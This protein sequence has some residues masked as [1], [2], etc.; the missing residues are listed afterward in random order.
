MNNRDSAPD[1]NA[2]GRKPFFY[3]SHHFLTAAGAILAIGII[4]GLAPDDAAATRGEPT[5]TGNLP[6]VTVPAIET[7]LQSNE[8]KVSLPLD[9][10]PQ[11]P[12]PATASTGTQEAMPAANTDNWITTTIRN[13]DNLS[14]I[15]GRLGISA[16][17]L[18]N[19]LALGGETQTLKNLFPGEEIRLQT[20]PAGEVLALTYDMDESHTLWV[21]RSQNS[22]TSHV[23]AHPLEKR[24]TQASGAISDSLFLS[25]QRAGLSDNLTMA[26]AGIFGWDIDFSL[27]IRD[28]DRFSVIYEEVYKNGEKLRDGDIL[29]AEFV[30]RGQVF[31]AVRYATANGNAQ[32]YSPTGKSL[33]K[34]FL[35]SPVAFTRVSS[36]FSLGRLH[37][38]LNKIR[39]HKGVDYAAPI[40]TPVKST[41]DGKIVFRGVKGGYGNA[42]IIQ[43]GSRYSTLYGHLSGFARGMSV[44]SRVNQGQVIGYVGMTGLA[45][46][47]HLHYE[48]R[49]DGVH[50]NPLTVAFPDA[51]PLT[52]Q[53]LAG[54]TQQSLPYL[55]QL[56]VL[57]RAQTLLAQ[58]NAPG[59]A[60]PIALN[61]AE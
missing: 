28:G 3:S 15:F 4:V 17:E 40:G 59:N 54:F 14:L 16:Q 35:R 60:D 38:I 19:V 44:G 56:D 61:V 9:L 48:F 33:R 55:A 34:A 47:P 10:P 1:A 8:D 36:G 52:A 41:G 49:I 6:A 18:H 45:T 27:D 57:N 13:G 2:T 7:S 58:R 21:L 46:G 23:V 39:A 29:A 5:L 51:A 53:Q 32:Y 31:R 12:A 43:H 20:G 25:S 50:R 37:P 30:N 26:L 11:P 42:V 24:I 22:F